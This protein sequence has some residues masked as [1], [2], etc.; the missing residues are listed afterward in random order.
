MA[1][2]K[3]VQKFYALLISHVFSPTRK[4]YREVLMGSA[5]NSPGQAKTNH[6]LQATITRNAFVNNQATVVVDVAVLTAPTVSGNQF[7]DPQVR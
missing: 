6:S 5:V 2:Y 7:G 3:A 1:R 4:S